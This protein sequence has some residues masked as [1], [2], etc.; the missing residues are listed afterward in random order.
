M[1][2]EL[3]SI[4]IKREGVDFDPLFQSFVEG[5]CKI[6]V[7]FPVGREPGDGNGKD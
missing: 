2:T 1:I 5:V 3:S 6:F 7:P 4:K